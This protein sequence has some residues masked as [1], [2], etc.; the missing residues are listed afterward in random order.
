MKSVNHPL[1]VFWSDLTVSLMSHSRNSAEI[2]NWYHVHG[3]IVPK[4]YM[5]IDSVKRNIKI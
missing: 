3:N 4:V 5:S 1:Y 2:I